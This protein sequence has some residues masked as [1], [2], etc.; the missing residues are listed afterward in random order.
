MEQPLAA[1]LVPPADKSQSITVSLVN[2]QRVDITTG[3][4]GDGFLT[5]S[6]AYYPGWRATIDG[7]PATLVRANYAFEGLPLPKGP[8]HVVLVYDPLS[9]KIGAAVSAL[10]IVSFLVGVAFFRG[11][12]ARA[13]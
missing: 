9:F 5:L 12:R 4:N 3:T 13:V 10:S 11:R 2:P 7:A 6:Y 1:P 8:H